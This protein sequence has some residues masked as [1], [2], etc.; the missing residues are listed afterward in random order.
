MAWA[1]HSSIN[2]GSI[3]LI[4]WLPQLRTFHEVLHSRPF[5]LAH[6]CKI[7]LDTNFSA[8]TSWTK[9][10]SINNELT[11][12]PFQ[13][14]FLICISQRNS[15]LSIVLTCPHQVQNITSHFPTIVR[16]AC[17]CH[18]AGLACLILQSTGKPVQ[19]TN[20]NPFSSH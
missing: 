17:V 18:L 3:V 20:R 10:N 5:Q 12:I 13:E 19:E 15:A 4:Y 1:A 2:R 11:I 16:L 8:W 7:I 14:F 9:P 6:A